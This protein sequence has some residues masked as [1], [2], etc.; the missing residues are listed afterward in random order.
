MSFGSH[1][2]IV[3]EQGQH[4]AGRNITPRAELSIDFEGIP[5]SST[6]ALLNADFNSNINAM[7]GAIAD[8]IDKNDSNTEFDTFNATAHAHTTLATS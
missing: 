1:N 2:D 4:L 6:K 3:D 7:L 8:T 5:T